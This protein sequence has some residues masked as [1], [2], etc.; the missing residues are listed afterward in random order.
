MVLASP[1]DSALVLGVLSG[2][3]SRQRLATLAV[4]PPR[5]DDRAGRTV[6]LAYRPLGI[7][8]PATPLSPPSG[9]GNSLH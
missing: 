2:G 7:F 1:D 4:K 6:V 9:T 5:L 8:F 3:A